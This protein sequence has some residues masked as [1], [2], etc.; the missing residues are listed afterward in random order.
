MLRSLDKS[1]EQIWEQFRVDG[2]RFGGRGSKEIELLWGTDNT[3][4]IWR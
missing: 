2:D 4:Q 1:E 3:F